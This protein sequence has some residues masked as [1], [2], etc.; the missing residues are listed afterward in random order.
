MVK[1][2][3]LRQRAL[4]RCCR[5]RAPPRP[6]A[7]RRA[8]PRGGH[9]RRLPRR[10]RATAS[11]TT[12]TISTSRSVPAVQAGPDAAGRRLGLHHLPRRELVPAHLAL[13]DARRRAASGSRRAPSTPPASRST[14]PTSLLALLAFTRL[15]GSL[16]VG[17][18]AA[19]VFALHPLHVESVAWAAARK[20]VLSGFFWMLA[21]LA[22]ER[23][24]RRGASPRRGAAVA[25]CFV[26]GLLAKPI[27]VTLP[28]VLLLLDVWPLRRLQSQDGRGW[29]AARVRRALLEKA[30]LFAIAALFGALV[31]VAQS[32]GG[33]LRR[34]SAIR[35]AF[36]SP[37]PSSRTRPI[38][39]GP[40][41]RPISPC[42]IRIPATRSRAA[43]SR[44][45]RRCCS[46]SARS[47]SGSAGAARSSPSAGSGG[48]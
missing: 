15:T 40:C 13:L 45:R 31:L 22:Y 43:R 21:L 28:F 44:P 23:W 46:V 1:N 4:L 20:D 27:L 16:G 25:L 47:R 41:F 38:C 18:F 14:S 35:S 30:G 32:A 6:H 8:R 36:A 26:L 2:P 37:T 48:W 9:A 34:S 19:G 33:A 42:S 7:R 10:A 39:A 12:T 24:A 17:A 29:D 11:S 3:R 5:R